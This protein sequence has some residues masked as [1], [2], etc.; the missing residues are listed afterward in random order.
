MAKFVMLW[1]DGYFVP[2]LDGS[3][4]DEVS[5]EIVSAYAQLRAASALSDIADRLVDV[6]NAIV[7]VANNIEAT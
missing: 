7:D 6:S 5:P 3:D 4:G 2:V 1:K